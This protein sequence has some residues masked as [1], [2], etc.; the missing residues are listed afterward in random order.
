M[1]VRHLG[2]PSQS[3]PKDQFGSD[4]SVSRPGWSVFRQNSSIWIVYVPNHRMHMRSRERFMKQ[5]LWDFLG[6]NQLQSLS[7]S[8]SAPSAI[9]GLWT[10]R[11]DVLQRQ[12]MFKSSSLNL[13]ALL[14]QNIR[15]GLYWPIS[16]VHVSL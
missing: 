16:A 1:C 5:K 2:E 6:K 13:L 3:K 12:R 9:Y 7:S 15:F 4:Q 11:I 8:T 10:K 14:I